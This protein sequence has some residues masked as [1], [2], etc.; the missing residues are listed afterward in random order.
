MYVFQLTAGSLDDELSESFCLVSGSA[1]PTPAALKKE[2]ATLKDQIE[3]IQQRLAQTDRL[4]QLRKEQD[5]QLRDSIVIAR[6]H[7]QKAMGA[8]MIGPQQ[9]P[10]KLDFSS[11]NINVPPVPAPIGPLNTVRD[12]EVPQLLRRVREL[13][14]EARNLKS[15]NE[16]QVRFVSL[17]VIDL[18][19]I[20]FARKESNDNEVS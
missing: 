16:K 20:M 10:P 5:M 8:S 3:A 2:N 7:A 1:E 11:L 12:R 18:T 4:L 15:E 9:R 14:E 19:D 6:Q 13:E 17:V